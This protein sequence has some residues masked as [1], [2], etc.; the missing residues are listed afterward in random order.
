MTTA[1][2]R[3]GIPA[4]V[5]SRQILEDRWQGATHD[6]AGTWTRVTVKLDHCLVELYEAIARRPWT[7]ELGASDDRPDADGSGVVTDNALEAV[8]Q[9]ILDGIESQ[10][11]AR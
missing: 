1:A 4:P 9:A 6:A 7:G 3:P 11:N 2:G 8:R 5:P 10:G